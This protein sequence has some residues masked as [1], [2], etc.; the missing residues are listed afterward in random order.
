METRDD[1]KP[2]AVASFKANMF[3][4]NCA[5]PD[6]VF[7]VSKDFIRT[8]KTPAMLLHGKDKPHPGRHQCGIRRA[9]A[10]RHGVLERLGTTRSRRCPTRY[11]IG[12]LKTNTP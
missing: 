2:E 1:I 8:L 11:G 10:R 5:S 9:L 6:L 3:G 12:F 7:S 4:E